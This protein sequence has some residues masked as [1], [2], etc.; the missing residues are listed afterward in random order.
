MFL[1][2]CMIFTLL[3]I[4]PTDVYGAVNKDVTQIIKGDGGGKEGNNGET[5]DTGMQTATGDYL[6]QNLADKFFGIRFSLYFAEGL[7]SAAEV[8]ESSEFRHVGSFDARII[9]NTNV[10]QPQYKSDSGMN[11]YKRMKT[12]QGMLYDWQYPVKKFGE[13]YNASV[14]LPSELPILNSIP[15]LYKDGHVKTGELDKFFMGTDSFNW[16]NITDAEMAK[17]DYKN[18]IVIANYILDTMKGMGSIPYNKANNVDG[19]RDG[20]YVDDMGVKRYGVLK[21]HYEPIYNYKIDGIFFAMTFRDMLA[22]I[23]HHPEKKIVSNGRLLVSAVS[24]QGKCVYLV[25]PEPHLYDSNGTMGTAGLKDSLNVSNDNVKYYCAP[26]GKFWLDGGVGVVTGGI[27]RSYTPPDI[28]RHYVAIT[29]VENGVPTYEKAADSTIQ[30]ADFYIDSNGDEVV[31]PLFENIEGHDS[32]TAVLNDIFT[33]D[34]DMVITEESEWVNTDLPVKDGAELNTTAE[35]VAG[36]RFGLMT[37]S[38][39]FIEAYEESKAVYGEM[40]AAIQ[41]AVS[42]YNEILDRQ[43]GFANETIYFQQI[44]MGMARSREILYTEKIVNAVEY[45]HHMSE[46][47]SL[48]KLT[49]DEILGKEVQDSMVLVKAGVRMDDKIVKMTPEVQEELRALAAVDPEGAAQSGYVAEVTTPAN[50]IVLRYILKPTPSQLDVIEVRDK[51]TDEVKQVLVGEK[52]DLLIN[53]DTVTIQDPQVD[54]LDVFENATDPEVIEWVTNGDYPTKD[55]SGGTLPEKS[56]NGK[57]GTTRVQI[58]SYPQEPVTHNLYVKWVVYIE[59]PHIEPGIYHVPEWRLSRHFGTDKIPDGPTSMTLPITYGCCGNA[60]LSPSGLWAYVLRN[61]NLKVDLPG[62]DPDNLKLFSWVHAESNLSLIKPTDSVS[63]YDP[64]GLITIDGAMTGIKSTDTS[65]HNIAK[66]MND[67]NGKDENGNSVDEN[68]SFLKNKYDI[69]EAIVGNNHS[70]NGYEKNTALNFLTLNANT[71][72]NTWPSRHSH[73]K[74]GH[75]HRWV[76][77]KTISPLGASYFPYIFPA[78]ITFDRYNANDT[79]GRLFLLEKP[80]IV[81]DNGFTSIKYQLNEKLNVYPEIGMT[82]DNDGDEENIKW[83]VG[84]KARTIQPVVWQTLQHKVYVVPNSTGTSVV[85]DSR[86]VK[87]SNQLAT[88]D[89]TA[90]GKQIIYKG[91]A[92][93]TAFRVY[94]DKDYLSN[95]SKGILTV[96]TYALDLNSGFVSKYKT[97]IESQWNYTYNSYDEHATMLNNLKNIKADTTEKLLIDSAP[98]NN[99]NYEGG[100][101]S[102]QSGTYN[103]IKYTNTNA[104]DN[105]RAVV[106]EHKLIV[107][108]GAVIGV[109][110]QNRSNLSYEATP[111][112]ITDLK[113]KDEALYNA[114]IG[115]NLYSEDNDRSKTVLHTFEHQKGKDLDEDTYATDLAAARKFIDKMD[116]PSTSAVVEGEGWYSEDSTILVVKEYVSNFEVPSISYSDKISMSVN[117]LNTPANKTEFFNNMGKGHTYLKYNLTIKSP[118][119]GVPQSNAYFEFTSFKNDNLEFGRQGVDYI[120]PNVSVSDTT[121]IN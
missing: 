97:E 52:Q 42:Y 102:Q 64:T 59:E 92:A 27:D 50:N 6:L 48:V 29:K 62:H 58:P 7:T 28:I 103:D 34:K 25:R 1:I 89:A 99:L 41:G 11:V 5:G 31:L 116:T 12:A 98:Y 75:C 79:T 30:P 16:N 114:I 70:E 57:E 77:S 45:T 100:V 68:N 71:Y 69:K 39:T 38:E 120:V 95:N 40:G 111:I 60:K 112:A 113:A 65:T 26:G 13:N 73:K 17:L 87:T 67:Y 21:L 36:Y 63:A 18:T 78:T 74:G 32:G 83:I 96:K 107:R 117:G 47:A 81:E 53:G 110:V 88:Q 84:D 121:R 20:Y 23:Q 15:K 22:Y 19:Y 80:E 35:D 105:G 33:T 8:T 49:Y 54:G 51:E 86:A 91:A 118:Y 85:N 3:P 93:N 44:D 61:P 4:Y 76:N 106:F 43:A 94:R 101:R 109:F 2:F 115:M 24:D 56:D 119:Q 66:W 90:R 72:V 37:G 9:N 46:S 82:F 10:A 14:I 55:I 108:G 104:V